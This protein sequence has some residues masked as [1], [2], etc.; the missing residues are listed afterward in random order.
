M[1]YQFVHRCLSTLKYYISFV[2]CLDI[3]FLTI[4]FYHFVHCCVCLPFF[5]LVCY[6]ALP[7]YR[8]HFSPNDSRKRAKARPNG[9]AMD[10]FPEFEVWPKFCPR[11][12][13]T[14]CNIVLYCT[15]IYCESIVSRFTLLCYHFVHCLVI[16]LMVFPNVVVSICGPVRKS[17]F[18]WETGWSDGCTVLDNLPLID[19]I[20][21]NHE[22]DL[23]THPLISHSW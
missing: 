14:V 21:A 23:F 9:R 11:S 6:S 4:L 1:P 8:G 20:M 16:S 5:T 2:N 3:I 22:I 13:C 15:V 18:K 7:I 19:I 17:A 10:V 12:C